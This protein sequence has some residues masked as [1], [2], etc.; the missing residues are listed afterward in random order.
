MSP[1]VNSVGQLL[2]LAVLLAAGGVFLYRVWRLYQPLLTAQPTLRRGDEGTRA[3]R[4]L[5][6][7]L[8]QSKM[9]ERP[10]IGVAHFLIFWGFI[11][12]TLALLQV[13]ADGLIHGV[14]LPI[15][16]SRFSIALNDALAA[17]VIVALIYAAYRRGRIR[18]RGLTTQPDAWVI[19]GMIA[20]HLS[21]QLLAEGFAAA[22]FGNGE[23]H[24]S[25]S[26]AVIGRPL[27]ALGETA[28]K[29]GFVGF[30][31]IDILLVLGLLVHI[32]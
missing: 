18:P 23:P 28:C 20:G 17:I 22:A 25:L 31:W 13:L 8:G 26:G 19:I 12:L 7:V 10:A 27:S 2:L 11:I 32:P 21:S 5:T 3:R 1:T 14:H 15:V 16:S 9:F 29:I 24:W 30:Y 6:M 4:V